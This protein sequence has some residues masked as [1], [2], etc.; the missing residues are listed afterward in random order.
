MNILLAFPVADRATGTSIQRAFQCLGHQVTV[1][2]PKVRPQDTF[3]VFTNHEIDLILCSRT[4]ALLPEIKKIK[5][6]SEVPIVCFNTDKR[7]SVLD[8]GAPL[9]QL[10][11]TVDILFTAAQGNVEEYRLHC[12]DTKV[13]YLSQGC[14]PLLHHIPLAITNADKIKYS[15]SVSFEGSVSPVDKGRRDLLDYL[16]DNGVDLNLYVPGAKLPKVYV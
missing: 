2:D 8:F 13:E 5:A 7:Q 3:S 15:C 14:D 4:A 11:R 9:M 10:F 12:P 16:I 6:I 1:V